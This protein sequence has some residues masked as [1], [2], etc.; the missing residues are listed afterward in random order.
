[1]RSASRGVAIVVVLM[2]MSLL[3]IVA[4]SI[5]TMGSANLMHAHSETESLNAFYAARAGAWLKAAQLKAGDP[6]DLS[7]P[8]S[9]GAVD[10]SFTVEV[11]A[12]GETVPASA[13]I[14]RTTPLA[15]PA[16]AGKVWYVL[17][18]GRTGSGRQRQVGLL[19]EESSALF[20]FAAFASETLRLEGS[21]LLPAYTDTW[22]SATDRFLPDQADL[23]RIGVNSNDPNS[24]L[25]RQDPES[26]ERIGCPDPGTAAAGKADV[27]A[28][29]SAPRSAV[30]GNLP[31][32]FASF[33]NLPGLRSLDPVP[34]LAYDPD[35][36]RY[37]AGGQ[38]VMGGGALTIPDGTYNSLS[39]NGAAKL[40]LRT[41]LAATDPAVFVFKEVTMRG[42]GDQVPEILLQDG[43]TGKGA[44]IYVAAG[45]FNMINGS[46]VNSGR[47]PSNLML[48]VADGHDIMLA[49]ALQGAQ[50]YYVCYAPGCNVDVVGGEI[51]GAVVGKNVSLKASSLMPAA[52]HYDVQLKR[53]SPSASTNLMLLSVQRL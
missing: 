6:G 49:A 3:A 38:I 9:M 45:D 17:A 11:Y 27:F 43:G 4:L 1:M 19:L 22:D 33:Q 40:T 25:F 35:A 42:T 30:T 8:Q 23:A 47:A 53:D 34:S 29:P 12:E 44:V 50:A 7:A 51:Y 2:C 46:L 13:F 52:V 5:M 31:E 41:D 16:S 15:V 39:L 37:P 24:V 21:R 28:G 10:A 36:A 18:T 20:D 32:D 48:K 14:S 26:Q